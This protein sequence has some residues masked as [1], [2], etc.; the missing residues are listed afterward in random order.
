M[1]DFDKMEKQE[2]EEAENHLK[3]AEA[4]LNAARKAEEAAG[5]EIDEALREIKEV[6]SHQH[7]EIHFTVDGE[8]EETERREIT[9][10]EI[11]RDFGLKDPSIYYLVRIEG[12]IKKIIT[13]IGAMSSLS[14]IMECTFKSYRLGQLLS[15][16]GLSE[17]G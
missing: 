5:H 17:L 14:F 3:K 12:V 9:P 7:H 10:N 8:P 4:D 11:I 13:R 6:E 1:D 2:L 16:M 15:Q